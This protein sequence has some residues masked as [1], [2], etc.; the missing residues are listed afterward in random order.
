MLSCALPIGSQLNL[1][2]PKYD[3]PS[4]SKASFA[5]RKRGQ[6]L[7]YPRRKLPNEDATVATSPHAISYGSKKPEVSS[8]LE[9]KG[10]GEESKSQ[11]SLE[12][13]SC[14]LLHIRLHTGVER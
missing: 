9:R 11:T 3:V 8:A 10:K 12:V 13:H 14:G 5:P 4:D 2:L 1:C 7:W 6:G